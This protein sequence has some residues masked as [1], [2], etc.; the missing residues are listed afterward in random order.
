[1]A[2]LNVG[3][4]KKF[5]DVRF[6]YLYSYKQANSMI[7]QLTDDDLGTGTGTNLRTHLIRVDLGLTKFF[8]WQNLLF[9][10][11]ELS[12]NDPAR[13]FFVPLQRGA[14]TTYRIQSQ[15]QFNF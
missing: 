3:E 4:V 1:M 14:E 11:D 15:F 13:R 5:G 8:Q 9:I 7:S 10:Q 6:L 2:T 12:P